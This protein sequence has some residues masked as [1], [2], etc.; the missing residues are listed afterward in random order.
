M[1]LQLDF[2]AEGEEDV[3][4]RIDL[5]H[6]ERAAGDVVV[7]PRLAEAMQQRRHQ[8]DRRAHAVG[9]ARGV[10]VDCVVMPQLQRSRREVG[11]DRRAETLEEAQQLANIDEVA[12]EYFASPEFD[13]LLVANVTS[14]FPEHEHEAIVER[15]RGLVGA[16]VADQR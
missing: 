14:V 16:W 1:V 8:H 13:G 3:D 6:A 10:G 5:A 2:G 9:Q 4:V 12:L 7:D 15:H 11:L